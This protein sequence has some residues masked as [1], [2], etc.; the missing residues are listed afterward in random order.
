MSEK[1]KSASERLLALTQRTAE[2]AANYT[3]SPDTAEHT[4][5]TMPAQLG[6]FRLEAQKYLDRIQEL[7]TLVS[8]QQIALKDLHEVPGRRRKLTEEAFT[9]LRENL[10]NNELVTPITVRRREEGGFEIVSGHNRVAAYRELGRTD[11]PA[12]VRDTDAEQANLN[13]FYANLLQPT[14]SDF[15]KYLGFKRRQI[16]TGMTQK[17]LAAEAGLPEQTVSSIYSFDRLPDEAKELLAEQPHRLG[18]NAATKLAQAASLG[19][20]SQVVEAVRKLVADESF[21]QN[22][23]VAYVNENQAPKENPFLPAVIKQG[24]TKFGT[25]QARPGKI[26]IDLK[27]KDVDLTA[28][29]K[30]RIEEFIRTELKKQG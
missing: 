30:T 4:P 14:L 19:K 26:V 18:G 6:A 9:E 24:K 7:E 21:T 8:Q 25:V 20:S 13:A 17:A 27:D 16:A 3:P 22:H 29:W 10:R 23:A 2:R 1:K 28:D 11:I 5:K 12:F 15:E